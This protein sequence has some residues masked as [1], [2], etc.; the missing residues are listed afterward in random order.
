MG[1]ASNCVAPGF[2]RKDATS[3][4]AIPDACVDK[5]AAANPMGRIALPADTAAAVNFL[6]SPE[7]QYITGQVIHVDGGLTLL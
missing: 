2:T 5:A 1:S 3:H 6:L 7:A 4:S